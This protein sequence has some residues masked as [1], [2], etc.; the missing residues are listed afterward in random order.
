MTTT[1]ESPVQLEEALNR[2]GGDREFFGELL[3]MFLEEFPAQAKQMREAL[4]SGNAESLSGVAHTLKGAAASLS[5][6]HIREIAARIEGAGRQR[7]LDSVAEQLDQLDQAVEQ[8][9]TFAADF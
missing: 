6:V 3:E 4:D 8:L 7:Q 9:T 1:T 5:A 2:V